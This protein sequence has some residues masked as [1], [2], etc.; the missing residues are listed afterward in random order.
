MDLSQEMF[1]A[2]A[3]RLAALV[4]CCYVVRLAVELRKVT[5]ARRS[6]HPGEIEAEGG[7]WMLKLRNVDMPMVLVLLAGVG[8]V[9]LCI[10]GITVTITNGLS[11]SGTVVETNQD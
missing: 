10:G 2:L 6:T 11:D 5:P 4:A 7:G 1:V 9:I 8:I 3:W